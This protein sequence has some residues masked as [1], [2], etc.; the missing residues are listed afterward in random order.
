MTPGYITFSSPRHVG[1]DDD[2]KHGNRDIIEARGEGDGTTKKTVNLKEI[3]V[4]ILRTKAENSTPETNTI[5]LFPRKMNKLG[6][7]RKGQKRG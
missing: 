7:D 2:I 4:S 6:L 3:P 1:N 5:S